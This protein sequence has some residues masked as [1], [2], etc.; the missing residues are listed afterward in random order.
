MK[1]RDGSYIGGFTANSL[2]IPLGAIL[3]ALIVAIAILTLGASWS[4]NELADQMQMSADYQQAATNLQAGTSVLSETSSSFVQAPF[5]PDGQGG[6]QINMNPLQMYAA[7][8][9]ISRRPAQIVA[10]FEEY[11]VTD[12]ILKRIRE[13]AEYSE[14][15][16]AVQ[17][18]AL[19]L[20]LWGYDISDDPSLNSIQLIELTTQEQAMPREA[21]VGAAKQLMFTKDYSLLKPAVSERI[22]ESH[23]LLQQEFDT[24]AERSH[25]TIYSLRTAL[26]TMIALLVFV[27]GLTFVLF[28]RWIVKPLRQ[29]AQN[30]ADD[31]PLKRQ[32]RVKELREMVTAHNELLTRRNKLESILRAAAETDSLTGLPNRYSFERSIFDLDEEKGPLAVLLF[33]VNFLKKTNDTKGHLAGDQLLRTAA[34]CIRES[35]AD[36]YAD[37]C[38]RIGGDEFA[39]ILKDCTEDDVKNKI[40]R[41][42]WTL[43]REKIS[44]S[45]GYGFADE[46]KEGSF[47]KLML[48]ADRRM[49]EHKKQIH[50]AERTDE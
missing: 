39:A 2:V 43:D 25:K 12:D 22:E 5:I 4:T 26:W 11:E 31:Q 14:Q 36:G 9:R 32:G 6:E 29:Y 38:F 21:R 8:L 42:K 23:K 45:V 13:A 48:I 50:G 28:Y 10:L 30:I 3:V 15:M 7:E 46:V 41:F 33:D 1:K 20:I 44:V 17:I 34:S 35:F 18:H 19:S 27:M 49:Y 47:K 37:N 16:Q 24:A 40:E